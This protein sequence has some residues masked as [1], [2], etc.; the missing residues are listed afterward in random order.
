MLQGARSPLGMP[1][2]DAYLNKDD[3]EALRAYLLVRRA[4]IA[5]TSEVAMRICL[6]LLA[7]ALALTACGAPPPPAP[8][9]DPI[10]MRTISSGEVV[11]F[12]G[13]HGSHV[14]LGIPYA[15]PPIGALRWRAPQ[16]A[17]SRGTGAREALAL[18]R[19]LP[20]VREPA[21][22]D[23]RARHRVGSEDCLTLNVWAP[24]GAGRERERLPVMFWIHGGGNVR[25]AATSTTAPRSRCARTSWS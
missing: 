11:G 8:A 2:F 13:A 9:S 19:A 25:A 5:L 17:A 14:W 18:R 10:T 22:G 6:A 4:Q 23:A 20:A 1:R 3:V 7:I 12:V 15:A 24:P 16:R 21:R